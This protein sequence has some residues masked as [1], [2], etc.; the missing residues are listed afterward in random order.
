MVL[1]AD[2]RTRCENAAITDDRVRQPDAPHRLY[3]EMSSATS[4]ALLI[5]LIPYHV[6][7]DL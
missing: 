5:S 1:D 3:A 4:G 7:Q 6:A 2:G